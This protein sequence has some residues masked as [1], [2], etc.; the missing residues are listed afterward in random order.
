MGEE[1]SVRLDEDAA[2]M[3]QAQKGD[4]NAYA[5]LHE[6]Y[7]R[8]VRDYLAHHNGRPESSEDLLQE[9]FTRVWE[10]RGQYQPGTPV[11][12]YLLGFARNVVRE[13][14]S[15]TRYERV[16]S[17]RQLIR[18]ADSLPA[19]YARRSSEMESA[20]QVRMI[21][22]LLTKLPP[23]QQ[24][25]IELIY[26]HGMHPREAA[27]RLRCSVKTIRSHL[28]SAIHDLK[29]MAGASQKKMRNLPES[30][31]CFAHF[32]QVLHRRSRF[33]AGAGF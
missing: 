4:R 7:V 5:R 23:R 10:H 2:L 8:L 24:R 16:S 14:Q 22:T 17:P 28:S 25:V 31:E 20:E 15:H 27:Q 30:S 18:L 33:S 26:F 6:K 32:S 19:D 12:A 9:V 11:P 29:D 3:V 13:R 1:A 21:K